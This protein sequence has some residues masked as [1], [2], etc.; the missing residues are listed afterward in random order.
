MQVEKKQLSDTKVQLTIAADGAML[1]KTKQ[2]VLQRLGREVK[3]PGFRAG[4]APLALLEKNVDA[5]LLQSE[6]L[7]AAINELYAQTIIQEKLRPVEQPEVSVKKFVP[8]SVLEFEANLEAIGEVELPDYTKI[9][10]AKQPVKVNDKEVNEVVESLR[11]R[12]AEKKEVTRAAA[13]GDE[14]LIDFAGT[15]AET[16][17]PIQGADGKAY[18]LILGSNSFIPGFEENLIGAKAAGE[19]TFTLTFPKDYGVAALQ[20]RKVAFKVQITTVSEL[21]KPGLDD[22]FAAKVGPVKTVAELKTDIKKEL[23][24]ERQRQNERAYESELIEKIATQAKVAIPKVLVD[25]EIDRE[26]LDEKQN[27]AYRGQTWQEHLEAEGVTEAEHREQ[28]RPGAELRVKAGLLLSEIAEREKL[29]VTPEELEIRI[30]IL[31]GQYQDKQMQAQLDKPEGRRDIANRLLTEKTVAKLK[32]YS[33][34]KG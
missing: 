34:T 18:P 13:N 26:E 8:F 24:I 27:L 29:S 5:N 2:T 3:L 7:D 19:K 25:E 30:Q 10:L 28:K 9:K 16:G 14:V 22:A 1:T 33:I 21:V 4:K 23:E 11:T 12:A 17:K 31:K 32:E 15:D 6:F 20:N